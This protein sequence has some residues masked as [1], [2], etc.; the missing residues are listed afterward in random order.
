MVVRR[1]NDECNGRKYKDS[2]IATFLEFRTKSNGLKFFHENDP[3]SDPEDDI[4]VLKA[5][6]A[7]YHNAS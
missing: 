4:E 7:Q 2:E 5:N 6:L 1:I 3:I